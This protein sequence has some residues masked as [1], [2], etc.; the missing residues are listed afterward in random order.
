MNDLRIDD[1]HCNSHHFEPESACKIF[2]IVTISHFVGEE[3]KIETE[4][5]FQE[6]I[7]SE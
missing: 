5:L 3:N 7:A 4:Q 2:R 6:C 1:K